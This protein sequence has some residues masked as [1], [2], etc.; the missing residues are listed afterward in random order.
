MKKTLVI[1]FLLIT[2]I[3][4]HAAVLHFYSNPQVPQPLFHVTLEYKDFVYEADT[5]A[6]G[7]RLHINQVAKKG[8]YQILIPDSLVDEAA[9]FSQLGMPF[10]YKF[11]WGNDKTYCSEL[12]GI[13]LGIEPKPMS[14]AGTHYLEYY[15]E[16][17]H[18]NDPGLSPDDIYQ[19]GVTHGQLLPQHP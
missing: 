3:R 16:W 2:S 13:A 5:R 11:I 14:F 4:S 15:P 19:F 8:H 7:R 10:D 18:R 6:G 12:V 1:V 9:L 17:I